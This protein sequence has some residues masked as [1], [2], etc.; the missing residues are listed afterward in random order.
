[1][2]NDKEGV[3]ITTDELFKKYYEEIKSNA[4]EIFNKD[5]NHSHLFFFITGEGEVIL[6]P[7]DMLMKSILDERQC[8]EDDAKELAFRAYAGLI[9]D[10]KCIGYINICE[11]WT[12]A[13]SEDDMD[14]D[15]VMRQWR[16]TKKKYGAIAKM[17]SRQ[18][19][20]C[21]N[22][23]FRNRRYTT[24]WHIRRIGESAILTLKH[25]I[26]EEITQKDRQHFE[27]SRAGLL[28]RAVDEVLGRKEDGGS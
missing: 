3:G 22:A 2:G 28:D 17:P 1:M 18:E 25:D 7:F 8:S 10:K 27:Y 26:D 4:C 13:P 21:I 6:T 24:I 5:K 19:I 23:R 15:A 11:A 12:M 16:D 20:L 14:A 9:D